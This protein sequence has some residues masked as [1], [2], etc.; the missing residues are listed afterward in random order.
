VTFWNALGL[1]VAGVGAGLTASIAGLASLFSYPA[2]LAVGLPP[3][4]ANVTNT[5]ALVFGTTGS[6]L[7]SRTELRGRRHR[8]R[9]LALASVIGGLA[10]GA[11]LL[12]TPPGSFAH[13]VP[14]LIGL[15][16]L[17][18]LLI[19][20]PFTDQPPGTDS[21]L[22]VA[23]VFAIGI[24]GGYFGA[25]AGVLMMALLLATTP[26][27]LAEVNAMKNIVLGLANLAAAVIFVMVASVDW[28]AVAWLG[29]GLLAGGRIGP[30]I[31]R[32]SPVTALRFVI[33]GLGVGLAVYLGV[34]AA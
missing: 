23:G 16:S 19:R 6:V 1:I 26:D 18:V 11:L 12:L 5:V 24:Y 28:A 3:V 34:Q 7:G 32:H 31:V 9:T 2:L 10:G 30:V 20:R 13:I 4:T 27:T 33:A 29:L 21:R 14:W 17:S 15:G 22:A 25:A 8:V